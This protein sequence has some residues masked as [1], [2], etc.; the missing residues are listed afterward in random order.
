MGFTWKG[1]GKSLKPLAKAAKIAAPIAGF[2]LGPAA[3]L[4]LGAAS[5]LGRG[6][7]SLGA[8]AGGAALGG[9]GALAGKL[10]G[11]SKLGV[12]GGAKNALGGLARAGKTAGK[13]ALTTG[14]EFDMQKM[15]GLAGAASGVIGARKDN[16]A[17]TKYNAANAGLR[18]DLLAKLAEK[19]D[20]SVLL[21]R[22]TARP[23]YS[24]NG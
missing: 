22:M 15:L 20:Y 7:K 14:G 16:A 10:A 8:M 3:G 18:N 24:F 11:V 5:G 9:A 21:D 23:N 1:L 4:A 2:A 19:P 17:T 6:K 12:M 13:A